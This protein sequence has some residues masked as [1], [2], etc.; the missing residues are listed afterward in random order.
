MTYAIAPLFCRPWTLNGIEPVLIERHYEEIYGAAVRRLNAVAGELATL[1]RATLAAPMF[2]RLKQEQA[3]LINSTV[4]HELYFASLGGDGRDVPQPLAEA[5]ARDFGSV[6]E[7]RQEFMALAESLSGE[8]GWVLLSWLPRDGRLLNHCAT[9]TAQA[10]A[11]AV[12]VL[13]LDMY[14]HAYQGQ[15]GGNATAYIAAFM[16]NVLWPAVQTRWQ[17]ATLVAPP[18]TLQQ[19]EFGDLPGVSPEE[20]MAQM[21]A[22][23][24]VQL[25][26]TRPR[27]YTTRSSEIAAGAV[28]RDPER[29]AEWMPA[30]DKSAPVVTYCVYGFHIGCQSAAALREA[31][32]D[33]RYM[34]GG[35]AAWK[36]LD[37]PMAL[38]KPTAQLG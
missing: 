3:R 21:A 15:F 35:H 34:R 23:H 25:I 29:L 31:G 1:N 17:G 32:F 16:R 22:G 2:G 13:A 19:P 38:F 4:L 11:G 36:A 26:D 27:H 37:G 30:L 10:L 18:L 6:D 20:V 14:E 5:L 9:D 33:V 12:P 7:W 24:K 8:A 28:W